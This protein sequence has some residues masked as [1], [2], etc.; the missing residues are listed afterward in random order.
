MKYLTTAGI[1][2]LLLST[3]A[4][5]Q[6][7]A[8]TA[9]GTFRLGVA[10]GGA[11]DDIYL[12]TDSTFTLRYKDTSPIGVEFGAF[13][14][15]TDSI[16][17]HETYATVNLYF[18]QGRS[19]A[20]GVPRPAYDLFAIS[21]LDHAHPT[22]ALESIPT[23]RSHAT[24]TAFDGAGVP[25]GVQYRAPGQTFDYALSAHHINRTDTQLASF[26]GQFR[27][28]TDITIA[29][30]VE[31]VD[32]PDDT[33]VNAKGQ[34]SAPVLGTETRVGLFHNDS[35]DATDLAEV[36]SQI[37]LSDRSHLTLFSQVPLTGSKDASFGIA[38]DY[39]LTPSIALQ[40]SAAQNFEHDGVVSASVGLN[41]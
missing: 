2:A 9:D 37:A 31:I 27:I 17:P 10:D 32:G 41:F 18:D 7:P 29:G 24:S 22:L 26:G 3:A 21:T 28:A 12:F 15:W 8:F 36:A 38:V 25:L 16:H 39:G 1:A 19:L 35:A 20:A 4:S 13:G 14:I 40:V 11:A 34:I 33:D 6:S 23:T 5:A 30:A